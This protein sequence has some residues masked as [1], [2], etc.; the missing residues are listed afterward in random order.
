MRLCSALPAHAPVTLLVSTRL[1][2][3]AWTASRSI[4]YYQPKY[5]QSSPRDASSAAHAM[6]TRSSPCCALSRI[7]N[8][9]IILLRQKFIILSTYVRVHVVAGGTTGLPLL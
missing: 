1:L 9:W 8:A 7:G 6:Y 5:R 4:Q 2:L 3:L